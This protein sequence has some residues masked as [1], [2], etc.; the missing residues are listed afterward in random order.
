MSRVNG[1]PRKKFCKNDCSECDYGKSFKR[2][3]NK[4]ARLEKHNEIL[5]NEILNGLE[6]GKNEPV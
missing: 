5:R 1:C 2:L 3:Y 6:G 4:I